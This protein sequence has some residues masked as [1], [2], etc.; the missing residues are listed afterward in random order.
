MRVWNVRVRVCCHVF[1]CRAQTFGY[2]SFH[3]ISFH[4]FCIFNFPHST[5][6][7]ILY[8]IYLNII[9]EWRI[10][11]A[12]PNHFKS[13][14]SKYL[15]CNRDVSNDAD[16]DNIDRYEQWMWV[17]ACVCKSILDVY[18]NVGNRGVWC[19]YMWRYFTHL[20]CSNS[21]LF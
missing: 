2:R 17:S 9:C 12:M 8:F 13:K 19:L 20:F 11:I 21:L 4:T 10:Y 1:L 5:D 16:H 18:I 14:Q 6:V 15:H 7:T 3:S